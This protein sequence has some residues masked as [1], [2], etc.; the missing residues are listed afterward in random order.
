MIAADIENQE[1]GCT[2]RMWKIR[3]GYRQTER[4]QT[5]GEIESNSNTMYRNNAKNSMCNAM[6]EANLKLNDNDQ[7]RIA[8]SH[9]ATTEQI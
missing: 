1:E 8:R 6:N 3:L 4:Q 9:L 7:I 2:C 5:T